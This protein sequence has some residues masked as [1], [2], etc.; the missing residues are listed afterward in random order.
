MAAR[1]PKLYFYDTIADRFD[2]LVNAYDLRRRLEIVFD[3][4]LGAG[5]LRGQ[6]VLDVGC[7][8]GWFSREA[9]RRGA[10]VTSLDIALQLLHETRRKVE[11]GR[12]N[13]D[14]CALPF[15][16]GSF[17]LVISSECIEHTLDP[18][19]ALREIHRVTRPG[20]RLLV[21]VPNQV[22]HFSATIAHVFKLRPYEGYE[23]WLGWWEI[24]R[25]L[26]GLHARIDQMRGFHL[27]PPLFRPT[28]PVLRRIDRL[29]PTIGPAMLNI[30]VLATKASGVSSGTR[31][32]A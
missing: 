12:V 25:I 28:W 16:S 4:L 31:T 20:G 5:D 17:D 27:V 9:A 13:G 30:A 10:R 18:R 29:G 23:H 7:G 1:D 21:T 15:A 3:E 8:T 2:E 14:A 11:T 19:Q 6:S 22:W 32:G 26:G 24:R